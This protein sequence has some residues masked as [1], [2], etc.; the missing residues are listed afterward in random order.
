MKF[1]FLGIQKTLTFLESKIYK[2]TRLWN[3]KGWALGVNITNLHNIWIVPGQYNQIIGQGQLAKRENIHI[4]TLFPTGPELKP[5]VFHIAYCQISILWKCQW[6][7]QSTIYW[8][9]TLTIFP[10]IK[11]VLTSFITLEKVLQAR[12][13]TT[14]GHPYGEV[15]T[16]VVIKP[17][18][19]VEQR[20]ERR[21]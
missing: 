7:I 21:K 19:E 5:R 8:K 16:V 6:N 18:R 10:Q 13:H 14:R 12:H 3:V 1:G 15:N 9:Q 11:K 2:K 17:K 4:I 20:D